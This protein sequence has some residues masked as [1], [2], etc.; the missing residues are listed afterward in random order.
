M[1]YLREDFQKAWKNKDP[2]RLLNELDGEVYR[3]LEARRTFRFEMDG[4]GYFAKVHQGI[5]W[6]EILG[7]L[8]R[9]R[10]PTLGAKDEW[11]ALNL[12]KKVGVQTMTPVAFGEKGI[13]PASK[14]SFLVTEELENMITLEDFCEGWS[15]K[16]PS[17]QLK[18]AII[19]KLAGISRTIHANGLNHRDYYLCHFMMPKA[20]SYDPSSLEFY[21]IDL[22]RAQIRISVPNRWILKDLSG[23]YY[24]SLNYGLNQR[25]IL[26]FI[27]I[28]TGL[29]LRQA[30]DEFNELLSK[31]EQKAM[32]LY[33]RMQRKKDDDRY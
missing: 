15:H 27:K 1:L 21:L 31:A 8:I 14:Q 33:D 2:F 13:N 24:S 30:L 19:T 5:G 3:E 25:D 4:K 20:Q 16:P 18:R 29:P 9:L 12:L 23:L 28:Y 32:K 6:P 22:H 7:D 11:K 10:T 26:R 17:F